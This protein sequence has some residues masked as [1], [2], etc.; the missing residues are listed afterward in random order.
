MN[1]DYVSH[2]QLA[3]ELGMDRSRLRRYVIGLG[4]D[5]V[6]RRTP[7]SGYQFTL[8]VS[9]EK[10][11]LIRSERKDQ[12]F[13]GTERPLVSD[14]GYFYIIY[15]EDD[16]GP[17]TPQ[18]PES[19][20]WRVH[21]P[22]E[23]NDKLAALSLLPNFTAKPAIKTETADDTAEKVDQKSDRDLTGI[24]Q[25]TVGQQKPQWVLAYRERRFQCAREAQTYG[26]RCP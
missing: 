3:A 4:I 12:G 23:N 11:A 5:S 22:F 14:I 8:T 1:E 25:A 7:D 15:G 10:A 20:F 9:K 13:L 6:K 26:S 24:V 2:K 18:R 16:A 17:A 21:T 19:D